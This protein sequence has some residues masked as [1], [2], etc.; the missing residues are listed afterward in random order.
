MGSSAHVGWEV[1]VVVVVRRS[2]SL[3]LGLAFALAACAND[4]VDPSAP[5]PKLE[6]F[7]ASG[8]IEGD[9]GGVPATTPPDKEV[10][11]P[12]NVPPE[13]LDCD[14]RGRW[15]VAQRV[16]ATAIGQDQAAHNWFYLEVRHEGRALTVTKGLHC[17][18]E[19]VKKTALGASVDSSTAWPALLKR[20]NSDNRRGTYVKEGAGCKLTFAREYVVRGATLPHYLA[21]ATPLPKRAEP[22]SASSPGW[23]DW[24]ADGN[25]GVSY[26]VSST[27]A[28]GTL[29]VVQRDWTEYAGT[30]AAKAQ[31]FKVPIRYGAEQ[32]ALGRSSGA[33]QAIET[34][35]SPSSDPA[36]HYAWFHK[37]SDGQAVGTDPTICESVRALRNTLVPE[38]NQ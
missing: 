11:P 36:Q 22:A 33:P 7:V 38:A 15:L 31:K 34:S 12:T 5:L 24:D 29:Y 1:L 18:F 2:F 20:N 37:L 30:T 9:G 27:L 17:G 16:L 3:G 21:P 6:P 35:S 26:K 19:V 8:A 14:L 28:A 23:E 13:D 4:T 10:P 32:I 25:P